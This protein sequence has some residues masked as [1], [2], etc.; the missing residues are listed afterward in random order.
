MNQCAALGKSVGGFAPQVP[1]E[2]AHRIPQ[3]L[4]SYSPRITQ[5]RGALADQELEDIRPSLKDIQVGTLRD[6]LGQE[7]SEDLWHKGLRAGKMRCWR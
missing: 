1:N 7:R 3:I 4:P 6:G 5:S 2:G